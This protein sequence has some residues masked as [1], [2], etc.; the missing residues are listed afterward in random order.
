MKVAR[1]SGDHAAADELSG[2]SF[3]LALTSLIGREADTE[4]LRRWLEDP[5]D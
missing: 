1:A 2:V 5:G 3:P 4:T